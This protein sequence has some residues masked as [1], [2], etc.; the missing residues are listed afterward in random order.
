MRK[1]HI[2]VALSLALVVALNEVATAAVPGN[3]ISNVL[4]G[5]IAATEPDRP[6]SG[7]GPS[8]G[9]GGGA[10]EEGKPG[11][12]VPPPPPPPSP[13]PSFTD[14]TNHWAANAISTLASRG[15]ITGYPDGTFKPDN[16]VSRAEI[17]KMLVL[18]TGLQSSEGR[19]TFTDEIPAWAAPYIAVAVDHGLIAGYEDGTFRS[20]EPLT[21]EQLAVLVARVLGGG[22]LQGGTTFFS[23]A[24]EISDWAAPSVAYVV[25]LGVFQG[26]PD[27]TFRPKQAVTRAEAA[28]VILR[29]IEYLER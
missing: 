29:L 27:G 28:M 11:E 24:G 15:I 25:R 21:R 23:D 26:Y 22:E 8:G 12:V 20:D 16:P 4:T 10:P 2:V 18:A 1:V 13:G 3:P 17:V 9:G 5:D 14:T 19:T 7:G 6:P